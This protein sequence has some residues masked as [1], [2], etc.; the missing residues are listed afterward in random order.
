MTDYPG[1]I[2]EEETRTFTPNGPHSRLAVALRRTQFQ[3]S[4]KVLPI[5]NSEADNLT[6]LCLH[7]TGGEQSEPLVI[8][9]TNSVAFSLQ[10][11]YTD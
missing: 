8:Y 2:L 3:N 6:G 4:C 9:K 11:N 10:D 5:K 7:H 1:L